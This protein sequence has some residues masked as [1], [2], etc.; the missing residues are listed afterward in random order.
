MTSNMDPPSLERP[1]CR[2]VAEL[3]PWL[4]NGSLDEDEKRLLRAHL[5]AC[6][7]CRRELEETSKASQMLTQHIPSLTLAEFGLG[8]AASAIER[9]RIERHLA[10]CPSCSH[11]LEGVLAAGRT[12]LAS[13][14][15]RT[16]RSRRRAVAGFRR[17]TGRRLLALA[18]SVALAL[19]S[20]TMIWSLV[21]S[22]SGSGD[23]QLAGTAST[24]STQ[25]PAEIPFRQVP[26]APRAE[27]AIHRDGFESRDLS[28]WTSGTL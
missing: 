26:E 27:A 12:D 28:A 13:P 6:E 20:G 11:E 15:K 1:T 24:K 23:P 19:A 4:L 8:L 17:K 16:L 5:A 10:L 25:E 18:A 7:S 3:L 14:S 21:A 22:D 2:E 9:E